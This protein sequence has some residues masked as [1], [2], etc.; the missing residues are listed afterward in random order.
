M[1]AAKLKIVS[2]AALLVLVAASARGQ[3]SSVTPAQAV[4]FMG[5]W[6][7]TMTE[8]PAFKGSQQTVRIWDENGR[9]AAS[10]QT[11]G[12]PSVV[13]GIHRDGGML[14]LTLTHDARPPILENGVPIS[15]VISLTLEGDTMRMAVMLEK[16]QTIKRGTGKKQAG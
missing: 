6:A 7:I 5:T 3:G 4:P 15:A 13:T 1:L 16:S 9:V 2:L 14:V 8:P 10:V 11:G 12:P